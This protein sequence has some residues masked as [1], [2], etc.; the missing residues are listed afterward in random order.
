MNI[1]VLLN[2]YVETVIS[3][4]DGVRRWGSGGCLGPERGGA[5]DGISALLKEPH[6]A[7]SALPLC[8]A[9]DVCDPGRGP[10]QACW[11]P[12]LGRLASRAVS[13]E[14][15]LFISYSVHGILFWQL[16]QSKTG[17]ASRKEPRP[18]NPLCL[19]H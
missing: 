17:A 16:E 19:A 14:L 7:A 8:E 15:L 2:L 18:A 10:T 12:D 11:D 5:P 9:C 1:C 4:G 6:R 13:S 3:K